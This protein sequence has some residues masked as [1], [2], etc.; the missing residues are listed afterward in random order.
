MA[1][2]AYVET[3]RHGFMW[4]VLDYDEEGNEIGQRFD[5][6]QDAL[7]YKQELENG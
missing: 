6:E 2:I 3:A 4:E 1:S 7:K 5:N